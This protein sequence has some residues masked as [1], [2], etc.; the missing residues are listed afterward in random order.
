MRPPTLRAGLLALN[1]GL[2]LGL[3]GMWFTPQGHL[4]RVHWDA[5]APLALNT[6]SIVVPL[7]AR[8]P[9]EQSRFLETLERPLF[10]PSRRPPP[11]PPPPPPPSTPEEA[12]PALANIHLYGLYGAGNS[13]G[14]I[15]RV[16][17]KN[18]R[19]TINQTIKGW[20]LTSIGESGVTLQRGSRQQVLELV[21]V[22]PAAGGAPTAQAPTGAAA[23]ANARTTGGARSAPAAAVSAPEP[24]PAPTVAPETVSGPSDQR[25]SP[26]SK[27]P[28]SPPKYR[29]LQSA[30]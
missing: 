7:P 26:A 28:A 17:G 14:A 11:P 21:H 12:T 30:R 5:P 22:I 20:K 9:P 24:A 23:R 29:G 4:R 1:F 3:L 27:Q 8:E 18:E 15:F 25:A 16:D 19:V 13:G 6:A 10:S 2:A